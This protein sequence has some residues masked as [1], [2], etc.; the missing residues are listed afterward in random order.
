VGAGVE[1]RQG[2]L[3]LCEQML[4]LKSVCWRQ[5]IIKKHSITVFEK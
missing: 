5:Y 2:D 4:P 3:Q 1:R